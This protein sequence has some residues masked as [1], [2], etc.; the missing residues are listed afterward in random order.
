MQW[1]TIDELKQYYCPIKLNAYTQPLFHISLAY[2]EY[3]SY[4]SNWNIY[5]EV[6]QYIYLGRIIENDN[7]PEKVKLIVSVNTY[8]ELAEI[9]FDYEML[10]ERGIRHLFINMEDFDNKVS[11]RA[12]INAIKTIIHYQHNELY[13]YVHC[14]AGRA[15]SG[16]LLIIL[17]VYD[18]LEKLGIKNIN[19]ISLDD[20]L[21]EA[22][23]ILQISRHQVDIG[24]S[25]LETAKLILMELL[26]NE[27]KYDSETYDDPLSYLI[28]LEF[29][30]IICQFIPFK[31]ICIYMSNLRDTQNRHKYLQ[32]FLLQ[33]LN[34]N[35]EYD[36]KKWISFSL[37]YDFQNANPCV[38]KID[39]KTVREELVTNFINE[40][41]SHLIKKFGN[42]KVMHLFIE[43]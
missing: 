30:N 4:T 33:I 1:L 5:D 15:R 7:I 40:I 27:A 10:R 26:Q 18:K 20:E 16:M 21:L 6:L 28:S 31:N 12:I 11:Y 24:P 23:R 19:D 8:G 13:T 42:E 34:A 43:S 37:L 2:N 3:K 22:I 38:L 25:K 17:H 29:K 41:K 9:D 36:V 35:D 32:E 14:K 39:D